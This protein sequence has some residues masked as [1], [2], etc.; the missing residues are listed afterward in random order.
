MPTRPMRSCSASCS[1]RS[2]MVD[3][4]SKR[5]CG[6]SCRS[7]ARRSPKSRMA[8]AH[9]DRHRRRHH[10]P[11][12]QCGSALSSRSPGPREAGRERQI[13]LKHTFSRRPGWLG[14][15]RSSLKQGGGLGR[16]GVGWRGRPAAPSCGALIDIATMAISRL[17]FTHRGLRSNDH[18]R[19]PRLLGFHEPWI[20]R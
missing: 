15:V 3:R 8:H 6:A 12:A 16:S 13:R 7:A 2:L 19:Y 20:V 11:E 1:V 10:R 5:C 14:A 9:G 17:D 18:V 4:S